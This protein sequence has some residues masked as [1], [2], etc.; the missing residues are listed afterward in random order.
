VIVTVPM[1]RSGETVSAIKALGYPGLSCLK[2]CECDELPC[3]LL[4]WLHAE[5]K[6]ASAKE[7]NGGVLLVG[8]LR[9]FLADMFC[10]PS[11]LTSEVLGPS[12]LNK[13]TEFLV[14]EL[15]AAQIIK[16]K[17]MHPKELTEEESEK[18]QRI[19]DPSR[20][21][22]ENG[23]F[24]QKDQRIAEVQAE[25]VL[26]LH[27]LD[28]D[29]SSQFPD[30]LS[31]VEARLTRL[32][33]GGMQD[34]LLKTRL[35]P[36]QWMK[37]GKLDEVLTA[38]Y[39]C[40]RQMMIKRFQVT[41]ES[42]AWGEK[43]K[44]RS[45]ALSTVPP[46]SSLARSSRVSPSFLLA[47]REDQSFILPIKAGRST[48]IYKVLMGS[49]PDRGGRPGEIEPPMPAWEGR[50]AQGKQW[51]KGGGHQRPRFSNKKKKGKK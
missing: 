39:R 16:H 34:S 8:E 21:E 25:W 44:E 30:V 11:L 1:D 27:A 23:D 12:E 45:E 3:P 40:R 49:V 50:R 20:E 32:P 22:E 29:T 35:T 37:L 26:L 42:F 6:S 48:S 5:L 24:G 17:N 41:L 28:M 47:A 15:L 2:R 46:L 43:E 33:S 51:G 4:T 31:E 38:D 13:I 7:P 36:D 9:K 18:E 10:P 19:E 14:S